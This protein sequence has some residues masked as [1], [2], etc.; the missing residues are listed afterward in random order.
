MMPRNQKRVLLFDE[1]FE[2]MRDL[3]E[4][5]EE[6]FGW[7]VA[8]TAEQSILERLSRERFDL[9]LV[10]VMIH[11]VSLDADGQEVRNV[12]FED[13][14]WL[15]TGLEFLRRLRKGEFSQEASS[16]TPTDVPVI[17]CSAVGDY[18]VE[19]ALGDQIKVEGH[20]EKPFRL[21]EM[22]ARMRELL[23]E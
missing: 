11:P 13:I 6:E 9:L 2:S 10:D 20:M 7:Y 1:D 17:V 23:E 8:L 21:K 18:S 19:D 22:V 5:I 12:H 15:I 16:G 14:S 3:K 4:H